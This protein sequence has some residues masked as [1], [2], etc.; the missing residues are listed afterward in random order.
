VNSRRELR[1]VDTVAQV[2]HMQVETRIHAAET[3]DFPFE[4]ARLIATELNADT[5]SRA[6]RPLVYMAEDMGNGRARI[7]AVQHGELAFY[8]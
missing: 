8:L 4:R 2:P 6:R 1:L 5:T 3:A 7:A